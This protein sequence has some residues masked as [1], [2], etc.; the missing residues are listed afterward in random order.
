MTLM[1]FVDQ[2][3]FLRFLQVLSALPYYDVWILF[4]N[5]IVGQDLLDLLDIIG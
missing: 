3:S 5:F 4:L 1:S 2:L